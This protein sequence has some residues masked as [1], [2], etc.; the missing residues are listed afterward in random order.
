M[1]LTTLNELKRIASLI[2]DVRC[3]TDDLLSDVRDND[4]DVNDD[5]LQ[6]EILFALENAEAE[7]DHMIEAAQDD[8]EKYELQAQFA[9]SVCDRLNKGS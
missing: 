8:I 9:K 4:L 5:Q 6:Y 3:M 7:I 1:K 2:C